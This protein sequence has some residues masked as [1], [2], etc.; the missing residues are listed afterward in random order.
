MDDPHASTAAALR[1]F[2]A[3]GQTLDEL[4]A[5]VAN[6]FDL[7]RLRADQLPLADEPHLE[8]WEDYAREAA[9][10]GAVPALSRRL[11]QLQWPIEAGISQT[12]AYRAATRRGVRPASPAA[13]FELED[14]AGVELVIHPTLAGR[15]PILTCRHRADFVALVR[16]CTARNEPQ[17]VPE[18]MGACIVT[19]LNNWDRVDRARRRMET[20][21]GAPFDEAGWSR[22]FAALVPQRALYQDRFVILSRQPYSGVSAQEVGLP[23]DE[24]RERSVMIRREHECTHYFT[25]RALGSMR[26]NLFDELIA[27]AAGLVRAF[28][29]YDAGLAL[30]F[31]G[32]ERHPSYRAGGRFENYLQSPPAGQAAAVILRDLVVGAARTI[33]SWSADVLLA[34]PSECARLVV[35]LAGTTLADLAGPD[36]GAILAAR[37]AVAPASTY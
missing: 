17:P 3:S 4:L 26:N 31:L 5:Y 27:D 8:A 34:G 22:A 33:E 18:S 9:R 7:A 32:L 23:D 2:G 10:D 29:R 36:G 6:P 28:G 13:G 15:I 37:W 35:A 24:W 19:G 14:P 25:L 21:R 30:R 11:V 1:G 12:D 16:A 20:E